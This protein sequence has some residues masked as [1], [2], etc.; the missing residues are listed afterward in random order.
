M[1]HNEQTEESYLDTVLYPNRI[2]EYVSKIMRKKLRINKFDKRSDKLTL[3]HERDQTP[4]EQSAEPQPIMRQAYDDLQ[5][6]LVDTDM[7]GE[8]GV[9]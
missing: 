1:L 2:N 6:G 4:G 9:E 5:R 3:P 8:R 7:H